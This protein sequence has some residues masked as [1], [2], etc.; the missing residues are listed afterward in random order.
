MEAEPQVAKERLV[1]EAHVRGTDREG[2]RDRETESQGDRER[3]R[4]GEPESGSKT[5]KWAQ[6]EKEKSC[7]SK[8][9]WCGQMGWQGAAFKREDNHQ[10]RGAAASDQ[11][12]WLFSTQF[13]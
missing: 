5:D 13:E 11:P 9:G 12:H 10:L 4:L 3:R 6:T 1:G 2:E 7:L 8:A